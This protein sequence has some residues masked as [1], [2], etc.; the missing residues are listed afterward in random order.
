VSPVLISVLLP[1]WS[2]K[3]ERRRLEPVPHY[4]YYEDIRR[5]RRNY[6]EVWAEIFIFS[7]PII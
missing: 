6:M 2:F 7:T 5:T 4:R 3:G 1:L